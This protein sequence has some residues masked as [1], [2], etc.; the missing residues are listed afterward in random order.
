LYTDANKKTVFKAL[1]IPA[2]MRI[3]KF[4]ADKQKPHAAQISDSTDSTRF[5]F[6]AF[7]TEN[8]WKRFIK[9]LD[10]CII[11]F[12]ATVPEEGKEEKKPV[13]LKTVAQL[14]L[15]LYRKQITQ[16]EFDDM[17][18]R[19]SADAE[20]EAKE[21]EAED[22]L[23]LGDMKVEALTKVIAAN[24]PHADGKVS[25]GNASLVRK[26][27]HQTFEEVFMLAI[28]MRFSLDKFPEKVVGWTMNHK[29]TEFETLAKKL[30]DPSGDLSSEARLKLPEFPVLNYGSYAKRI[31]REHNE[32][33]GKTVE[34]YV[35]KL[36]AVLPSK[37]ADVYVED[38]LPPPPAPVDPSL[39]PANWR[40]VRDPETGELYWNNKVTGET[41]YT[42]PMEGINKDTMDN[43]LEPN[44]EEILDPETN[45]VYYYNNVTEQTSWERPVKVIKQEKKKLDLKD[46]LHVG[47]FNNFFDIKGNVESLLLALG[48]EAK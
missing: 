13:D 28:Q 34:D 38:F 9:D 45:E 37:L 29:F 21:K 43:G 22:A 2:T 35:K 41:K 15:L 4:T 11:G 19:A 48:G 24:V 1:S 27:D 42:D 30:L 31:N 14:N 47:E 39:D 10:D 3:T 8:L 7:E 12:R 26:I 46:L 20:A 6:L 25:C 23:K 33:L 18:A 17:L 36:W 5:E 40:S 16:K 44:W 32:A